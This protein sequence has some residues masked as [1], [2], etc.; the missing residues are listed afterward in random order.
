MAWYDFWHTQKV[1]PAVYDESLSY[2]EVLCKVIET[3]KELAP[4]TEGLDERITSV[5]VTATAAENAAA[6]AVS[7][8]TSADANAT[9]AANDCKTAYEQSNAALATATAAQSTANTAAYNASAA[10][11]KADDAMTEAED[12]NST[13]REAAATA[14]GVKSTADAAYTTA[15][16]AYNRAYSGVPIIACTV[17][18][19]AVGALWYYNVTAD[20]WAVDEQ[21][22]QFV[23]FVPMVNGF[24]VGGRVTV[25]IGGKEY[26]FA[27]ANVKPAG[28]YNWTGTPAASAIPHLV[29]FDID[30][31]HTDGGAVVIV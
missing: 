31:T 13:A 7:T 29:Y 12:A 28:G 17:T 19:S 10:K 15:N 25:N 9:K 14:G 5:E 18:P 26:V 22:Q 23:M 27:D 8:A 20:G 21:P 6:Q 16:A 24:Q 4:L 2:Y 30:K 11:D 3:L 1:L